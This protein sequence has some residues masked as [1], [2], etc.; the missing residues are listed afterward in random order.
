MLGKLVNKFKKQSLQDLQSSEDQ[1]SQEPQQVAAPPAIPVEQLRNLGTSP[2]SD[3]TMNGYGTRKSARLN[4]IQPAP[5]VKF[6]FIKSEEGPPKR[7]KIW[8]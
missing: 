1:P 8:L 2:P 7:V 3:K 5:Q 6:F 4:A